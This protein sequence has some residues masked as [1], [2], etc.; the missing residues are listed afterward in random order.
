MPILHAGDVDGDG[1]VETHAYQG[2]EL[3]VFSGCS[4]SS[5][6][7]TE[8][9]APSPSPFTAAP[10]PSGYD[11]CGEGGSVSVISDSLP[12]ADGCL[13]STTTTEGVHAV[14]T[15]DGADDAEQ[16]WMYAFQIIREDSRTAVSVT[17]NACFVGHV[18]G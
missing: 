12:E 8:R 6:S 17:V 10:I 14:Y 15:S 5:S 4:L 9:S 16:L 18:L 13:F 7:S 2:E 1:F 11:I 3:S